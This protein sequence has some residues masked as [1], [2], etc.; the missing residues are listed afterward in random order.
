MA[1]PND[2]QTPGKGGVDRRTFL[3]NSGLLAGGL[4]GGGLLGSL[5]T[6]EVKDNDSGTKGGSTGDDGGTDHLADAR[7]FFNR[8]ED[9]EVL[10]AATER[11]FP[12]DKNGP[13]AIKLGVPYFIDRQLA[14]EW[15]L[16]AR[17]YMKGPFLNIPEANQY[18]DMSLTSEGR[19]EQGPSGDTL[20]PL[21]TPRYQTRM[22]RAEM[23]VVG[24]RAIDQAAREKFDKGF[25]SLEPEQ[26][27]EILTHFDKDEAKMP[28]V[29]SS[30]FFNLLAQTTLEGAYSDPVYGGNRNMDGWR[31]MEYPGPRASYADQIEPDEF[32]VLEPQGLTDYQGH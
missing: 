6:N 28:G 4:I 3:K 14:G 11:I 32:I 23:F 1:E 2:T 31:M 29:S 21:P 5:I 30:T 9:F 17:E 20:N 16:N 27:D 7:I 22:T 15:G 24:V 25:K 18:E 26:Q 10:A 13:G 19:D 8:Q 12:E